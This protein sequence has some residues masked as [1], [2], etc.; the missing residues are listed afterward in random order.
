MMERFGSNLAIT[1]G[2]LRLRLVLALEDAED[3]SV[4]A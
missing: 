4:S 1:V 3:V 2:G